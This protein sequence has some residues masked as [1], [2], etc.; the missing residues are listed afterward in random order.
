M[1]RVHDLGVELHAVD[2]RA[3]GPRAR[4]PGRRRVR[5]GDGEAVGRA[6]DGV[7]V[8]HPHVLVGGQAVAEQHGAG[9][10]VTRRA[11]VR[12]YSPRP[13]RGD[14][15]AE[16]LG[17]ELGAV[18]D[19][20]D[21]DA[22]VVDARGRCAG[23]PSTCT[24]VGPPQ[25]MTPAGLARGDLGGGDRVRAR[26]RCRRAPRAPGGRSAGRTGRRSRRRGRCR[27]RRS[28]GI[29]TSVTQWPMPTPCARCSALPSV[30]SAGAT[31]TSAF[32]NSLSV[33]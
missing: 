9:V 22:E 29:G 32:W 31:M 10:D 17:D 15:A 12:P 7:E 8:A 13:V 27:T 16:L 2:A 1:R 28:A 25:K 30:C 26:S 23:A 21:R 19:A 33:S 14:L 20:E 18:A 6:G 24:D 4:R 3:R 5:G 11:A